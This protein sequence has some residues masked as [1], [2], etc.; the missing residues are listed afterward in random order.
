MYLS[1]CNIYHQSLSRQNKKKKLP[2]ECL[3]V[4]VY[5]ILIFVIEIALRIS[6]NDFQGIAKNNHT[7]KRER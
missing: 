3:S 2:V 5:G 4:I 7:L 6:S 1:T